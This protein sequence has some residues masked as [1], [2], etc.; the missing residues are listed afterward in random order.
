MHSGSWSS[1][2]VRWCWE[3]AGG[4]LG[5]EHAAEDAFQLTFLIFVKKAG[6]LRD[7]SLL[8]NWLY[9][10]ALRVA[11]KERNTD[12]RREFVEDGAAETGIEQQRD[13]DESSSLGD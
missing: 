9:G 7:R 5:D 6:G 3:F 1:G 4:V 12:A 10:V 13:R 8:T 11:R 2:M